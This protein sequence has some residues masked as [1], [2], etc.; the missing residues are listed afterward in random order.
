MQDDYKTLERLGV[1]VKGKIVIARYGAGWRGLKPKLAQ[2]HGAVGCIIYSDPA[3]DGYSVDETYPERPDAPAAR[4]PA[5]LG[6]RHAASIPGDPL[7]PGIGATKDAKRLETSEAPTILKIPALPISY[8]DAQ[9][10]LAALGGRVVPP[11][12]RGALADHLSRRTGRSAVH[13]AVKSDWSLKTDLRRHRDD[14]GLDLSRPMG[15]A[16]QSSRRLGVRRQRSAVGPGRAAGRGEGD[17]RTGEAGMAAQAHARLRELGRR[18]ADAAG[19][20]RMGRRRMP[21]N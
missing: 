1:S 17:R 6:R 14:E 10:L 4:H 12:W 7:T 2:D 16:R 8:A 18:G 19:L 15:H 3:D 9:V 13:L 11:A 21:P 5:R 20:D